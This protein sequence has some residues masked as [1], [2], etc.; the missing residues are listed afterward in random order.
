MNQ[1][2]QTGRGSRETLPLALAR[3]TLEDL[4]ANKM[5]GGFGPECIMASMD[6]I[7]RSAEHHADWPLYFETQW[8]ICRIL[9]AENDSHGLYNA[10]ERAIRQAQLLGD[11]HHQ[12]C[13]ERLRSAARTL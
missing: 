12:K 1:S 10:A 7:I 3:E 2:T 8:H 13:F 5:L 11:L 9:G 4:E 6:E